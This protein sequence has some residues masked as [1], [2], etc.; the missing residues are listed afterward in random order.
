MGR[1]WTST[2]VRVSVCVCECRMTLIRIVLLNREYRERRRQNAIKNAMNPNYQRPKK[3]RRVR[4][5]AFYPC[6]PPTAAE[7]DEYSD[8]DDDEFEIDDDVLV[9]GTIKRML[10]HSNT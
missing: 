2:Q 4:T 9:S 5:Q 10:S 7:L 8:D 1:L 3:T 6:P